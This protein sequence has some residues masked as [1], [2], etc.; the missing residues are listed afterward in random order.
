MMMA[1]DKLHPDDVGSENKIFKKVCAVIER[2]KEDKFECAYEW[3][4]DVACDMCNEEE[5]EEEEEAEDSDERYDSFDSEL[6]EM[7]VMP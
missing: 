1:I 5:V 4:S 2:K 3:M 7:E 6:N